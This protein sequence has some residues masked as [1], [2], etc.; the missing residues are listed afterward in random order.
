MGDSLGG[1][2]NGAAEP[3]ET[4]SL[5]FELANLGT[6][7]ATELSLTLSAADSTITVVDGAAT[8]DDLSIGGI[9]TNE[10]DPLSVT[11]GEAALEGPAALWIALG[12]SAGD[13]QS[14]LR[15]DLAVAKREATVRSLA[16]APCRPNPFRGGTTLGIDLPGDGRAAH[17]VLVRVYNV[18]GRLVATAFDGELPPGS[19]EIAWDGR[20][21]DGAPAASGV[22]F[23]RADAAG[24]TRTRKAVLLK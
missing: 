19:H 3:G 17:R 20:G 23:I 11:I 8:M 10:S 24:S 15:Y 16:L 22:Y 21:S 2:G 18:A 12:G 13:A 9:G 4:V 14:A 7:D 1:N 6:A 5:V